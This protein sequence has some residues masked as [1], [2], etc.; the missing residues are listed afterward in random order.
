MENRPGYFADRLYQSMKGMGTDDRALIRLVVSRCEVDMGDI[1]QAFVTKYG[2]TL[3][4][5][6]S[7]SFIMFC[8]LFF[9][10]ILF[11]NSIDNF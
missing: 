3:D 8:I 6:I 9:H 5:F 11:S 4:S 2:K 1:K 10:L 7:V